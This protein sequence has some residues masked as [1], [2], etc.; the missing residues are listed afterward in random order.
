M[1]AFIEKH[2]Q[3]IIKLIIGIGVLLALFLLAAT[4]GK[5]KEYRFIGSGIN[6]T[7]TITVTGKGK[8]E[9]APDTA[10]ISFSVRNEST[11]IK[12]AQNT[13]SGKIDGITKALKSAGIDEKDVK[14][15]SYNSYPQYNYPQI[16]CGPG[17]SRQGSPTIRGYEVIHTVTIAVKDLEKVE[18]VLGILGAQGV[19]DMNG[20]NFGFED[21]KAVARE[22]RDAAIEDAK[23]EAQKLARSLGVRL[24]RIASFNEQGGF[25][26]M[27]AKDSM[28]MSVGAAVENAPSIPVGNQK[29]ESNVTLVYEIR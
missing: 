23:T 10:R 22:A 16:S 11:N 3:I 7:N 15:D 21:D 24:V 19:S 4:L 17:C 9:R 12:A 2:Q 14:T 1:T 29:I 8:V 27:Y 28:Q 6:A 13:V 25:M 26:P 5:V 18:T 20:P